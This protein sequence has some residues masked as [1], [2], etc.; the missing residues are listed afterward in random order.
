VAVVDLTS[1][2]V[3]MMI[4]TDFGAWYG[5]FSGQTPSISL[6]V[7]GP[8]HPQKNGAVT[9][10]VLGSAAFNPLAT[11]DVSSL[12]F[13]ATGNERSLVSCGIGGEDVNRDG[14]SDLVCHFDVQ[15]T[16]LQPG[17]TQ[18]LLRGHTVSKNGI[19]GIV[20]VTVN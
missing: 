16:N 10:A 4:P 13:G 17:A 19:V 9:V 15:L 5:T 12:Q 11:L 14:Y 8:I 2:N 7:S 3:T 1:N 18:A 20:S 6:Y